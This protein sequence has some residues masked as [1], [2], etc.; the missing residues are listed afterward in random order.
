MSPVALPSQ[1]AVVLHGPK[2][3]RLEDR[4]LFPPQK[5]YAQVAV[6]STGLCGSDRQSISPFFFFFFSPITSF[7]NTQYTI[8]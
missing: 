7:H 6:I 2:D 5:D 1:N 8:I 4:T 3:L